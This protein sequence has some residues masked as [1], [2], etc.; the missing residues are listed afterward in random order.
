MAIK[1]YC[2]AVA[3]GSCSGKTTLVNELSK[4][5]P[6]GVFQILRQDDYY[7]D[8]SSK[9]DFDGGSVNFDHPDSLE[10]SLLADHLQKLKT[11]RAIECPS[12]D[13]VTHSRRPTT[14]TIKATPLI[15]VD[16]TLILHPPILREVFDLRLF[17]SA[18]VELRYERRLT[19]DTQERGRTPDGVFNQ[20]YKQVNPMHEQ[21]VDP[22]AS[23]ADLVIHPESFTQ[24]LNL[25]LKRLN[26]QLNAR[27]L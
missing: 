18:P 17:V 22:S 12:Y 25:L 11:G 23:H 7:I 2:I 21:F 14:T 3:G 9:F 20:F 13:F 6:A 1:P 8:Q 19:R 4:L 16:G 10:L 5:L 15:L 26:Q 27:H 24:N